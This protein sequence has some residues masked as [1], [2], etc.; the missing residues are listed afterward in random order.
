ML[1]LTQQVR[2]HKGG[3]AGAVGND[4]DLAGSGDH[5]DVHPP[6]DLPLGLRHVGVAGADDLVHLGDSL[7]TVCQGGDGLGAAGFDD[8]VHTGQ[9]CR[10]KDVGAHLPLPVGGRGDDDL[11]ASGELGRNGEHQHGGGIGRRAAGDIQAHLFNGGDLLT[12]QDAVGALDGKA[13]PD[14]PCVECP[15]VLRGQLHGFFQLRRD[16]GKRLLD[17][18]FADLQGGKRRVI[19]ALGICKQGGVSTLSHVP[20]DGADRRA[21]VVGLHGAHQ[22]RAGL[23]GI[24]GNDLHISSPV[25]AASPYSDRWR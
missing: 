22:Q 13:L 25:R 5:I 20:H 9:L 17:L 3:V 7:R 15:D 8:P 12:H 1:R 18:F 6:E 19:E 4:Q 24:V 14:L 2:S 11:A 23:Q 21:D 10:G 16:P